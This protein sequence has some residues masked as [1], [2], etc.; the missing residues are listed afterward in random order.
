MI[1]SRL[2][3]MGEMHQIFE[4]ERAGAALDRVHGAKHGVDGFR[5]AVAIVDREKARLQ[6]GKLFLAFLEERLL[7]RRHRIHKSASVFEFKPAR[8]PARKISSQRALW[9][10]GA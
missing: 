2:E 7:D 3:H 4:A 8:A 9:R 5:V 6:L 10:R 1:E